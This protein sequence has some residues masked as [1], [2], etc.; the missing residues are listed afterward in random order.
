MKLGHKHFVIIFTN[1]SSGRGLLKNN[2]DS[3]LNTRVLKPLSKPLSIKQLHKISPFKGYLHTRKHADLRL[4]TS[5]LASN[6]HAIYGI[7][8]RVLH[9]VAVHYD[10]NHEKSWC[11][12]ADERYGMRLLPH[13]KPP[14]NFYLVQSKSVKNRDTKFTKPSSSPPLTGEGEEQECKLISVS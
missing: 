1:A 4:F 10:A 6:Q 9:H 14:F 11:A 13:E 2:R 8:S 7:S 5:W 12:E 3:A